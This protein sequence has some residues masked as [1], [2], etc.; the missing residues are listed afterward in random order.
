MAQK[1]QNF[2][3][4]PRLLEVANTLGI[5]NG[6]KLSKIVKNGTKWSKIFQIVQYGPSLSKNVKKKMSKM[7]RI[8]PTG[9]KMVQNCPK[10]KKKCW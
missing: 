7:V 8:N 5:K 10:C 3:N 4:I 6:P 2:Q 9:S 1:I